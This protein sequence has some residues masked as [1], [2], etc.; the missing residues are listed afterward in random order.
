MA[1]Q[2][3]RERILEDEAQRESAA[4]EAAYFAPMDRPGCSKSKRAAEEWRQHDHDEQEAAIR[5]YHPGSTRVIDQIL[6]GL[7]PDNAHQL[8]YMNPWSKPVW[9]Q[10]MLEALTRFDILLKTPRTLTIIRC[11]WD[12]NIEATPNNLTKIRRKIRKML[13]KPL[14]GL[15][16]IGMIEFAVFKTG[17]HEGARRVSPHLQLIL[18]GDLPPGRLRK[19]RKAFKGGMD[20]TRGA[21]TRMFTDFPGAVSYT[22]KPPFCGYYRD[23]HRNGQ[24]WPRIWQFQSLA[25]RFR[26]WEMFGHLKHPDLTV[27]GGEGVTVKKDMLQAA[28]QLSRGHSL[29]ANGPPD[30]S[31][32][33]SSGPMLVN[34]DAEVVRLIEEGTSLERILIVT[35][36]RH[37]EGHFITRLLTAPGL[38]TPQIGRCNDLARRFLSHKPDFAGLRPGFTTIGS[39]LAK[40]LIFKASTRLGPAAHIH[41]E[42]IINGIAGFKR[43]GMTPEMAKQHVEE[44]RQ[45][46]L[47]Q[48]QAG[49][50]GLH[51]I[52]GIYATYQRLLQGNNQADWYDLAMWPVL[53]MEADEAFRRRCSGRFDAVFV[54]DRVKP[55]EPQR[56][57]IQML[58]AGEQPAT[59]Y[60]FKG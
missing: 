31:P 43:R 1:H 42:E 26:L 54:D 53:G 35:S 51:Y 30:P 57:L 14:A 15:H 39:E 5:L 8:G 22:V 48:P 50:L 59:L 56:R 3:F 28:R 20:G 52:P 4:E 46:G 55:T 58:A 23:K 6:L 24:R 17:F 36:G 47:L 11:P 34:L 37:L 49:K 25:T 38:G 29:K 33:M 21:E 10:L 40:S 32:R 18:W 41:R 9:D 16:Y 45:E 2:S 7:L 12:T 27:A 60:Q 13:K 19:L 44:K